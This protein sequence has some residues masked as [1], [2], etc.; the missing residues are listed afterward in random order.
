MRLLTKSAL[1]MVTALTSLPVLAQ[2]PAGTYPS[3]PIR[4]IVPFAPGGTLDT[5]GRVVG[6]KLSEAWGQ[7]VVIDNRTGAGGN[8]GQD[9]GAKSPPDGYTLVLSSFGPMIISPFVYSKL[10]YDPAKDLTPVT[11]VA[12]SWFY[13]VVNPALGVTSVKELIA[14]AK[15][16]PGQLR[17]ATSGVASPSHLG[18]ALLQSV[19]GIDMIHVPYKG[20]V[21]GIAALL[22]GEVQLTIDGPTQI[23]PQVKAGKLRVL[24]IASPK[25][26]L[27]M[28][29]APTAS[30]AG[31]PG[32]EV[33]SWY[34]FHV[35]AGTPKTAIDKLHA[36]IA[37]L[38][39]TQEV[40]DRL[41]GV[42]AETV[43]NN[44]PAQYGEF[45]KAELKKWEKV[46][47]ATGVKLD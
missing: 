9:L 20:G 36:E 39:N 29:E 17:Y 1:A 30:E 31:M 47:R 34:G 40:R 28:P 14:L 23:L 35:P 5:V 16:K 19:A 15:A 21:P 45:I 25:R 37:K 8:I 43:A 46:I 7:P 18:A 4:M 2:N 38:T 3:R 44:S 33:G 24:A 10:P 27:L 42:G 13:L 26:S 11:L 32:V 12:T 22:G 41:A 6:Q